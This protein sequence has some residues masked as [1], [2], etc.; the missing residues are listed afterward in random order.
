MTKINALIPAAGK[1]TN[2]IMAHSNLPDTMIPINGKP[3][4]GYIIEDLLSRKITDITIVLSA[5]DE[6]TEKYL[7]K[8]FQSKCNL[9]IIRNQEEGRGL[10][11]SLYLGTQNM[12]EKDGLL[13]ILG[14]TIYKGE[15]NFKKDFLIVSKDYEESHKW[16]FVEKKDK[17][18]EFIDKPSNYDG[19]GSI[20]SGI[21][22]F[23]SNDLFKKI[24]SKIESKKK[25]IEMIDILTEYTNKLT[26][27]LINAD[28]WYDCGNLE[29]YYKAK[30]DFLRV[31][32]FNNLEYNDVYG[33]ITKKGKNKDKIVHE[34]N[35]Y[36]NIPNELKVFTP[37]LIDHKIENDEAS[38]S[39]E[40]YGYQTLADI[41]LFGP[42][43]PK[44]WTLIIKRL[45]DILEIFKQHKTELPKSFYK[46]IYLDKTH[47]RLDE[48]KEAD[49]YWKELINKD[50]IVINGK[51]FNNLPHFLP[52]LE[53]Q[54]SDLYDGSS[55]CIIH[56]DPCLSNILFDPGSRIFKFIDPRGHFGE[57]S[58]YG[59]NK[60]DI[61]KLRHSF[62]GGYEFIIS[63]L[64]EIDDNGHNFTYTKFSENHHNEILN[65]FDNEVLAR[66]YDIN[67][68]KLIES[69]LFISMIPI[70]RDNLNRQ[71]AMYITGILLLNELNI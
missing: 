39:L 5:G 44:L 29:N 49:D 22:Y 50:T 56:G 35:W 52:K 17:K 28:K 62:N 16:C 43:N 54:L 48:L 63:D 23:T 24:I 70:H 9:T 20:L 68:I 31:R 37:R 4:I 14:D 66:G 34:I 18:L 42:E 67:K 61:A 32:E 36:Q 41:F 6:Y 58:V 40:Y 69:L 65:I 13:I 10:G 46:N 33:F 53:E 15:L 59:H 47:Q 26:P 25:K 45:M 19:S 30:I 27:R 55:M 1:P 57:M 21:Y 60:Y 2:M 3:V 71:K 38:Y 8:K 7:S 12:D 51:S 64:F 11:Y